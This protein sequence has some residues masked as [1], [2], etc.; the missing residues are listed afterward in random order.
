M[1]WLR[2]ILF[3]LLFFGLTALCSILAIP[4]L[5]LPVGA[6]RVVTRVW[7]W[8]VIQALRWSL[9]VRVEVRGRENLPQGGAVVA[10][11]HQ[12][13]FDTCV[14]FSLLDRPAYVMK[15]E[16]LS[17]PVFGWHARKTGMIPVDRAGG[18]QALRGMLRAASATVAAGGQVVI[19]PEGTRTAPGQRVPYQPGVVAIAAATG[20]PVIPVATDSGRV[21][22]RRSFLKQPGV[23]RISVLPPLPAGLSRARMLSELESRIED[24]T[25]RLLAE[26]QCGYPPS[27]VDKSVG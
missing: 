7:A 18:G 8:L 23:I 2:S 5:L 14:W 16:L 21:W 17:I 4:C 20:V 27:P 26:P 25:D 1:I 6:M 12:S 11:K 24:E 15:K 3:N 9:G 19:F 22:G 13:A 10:A